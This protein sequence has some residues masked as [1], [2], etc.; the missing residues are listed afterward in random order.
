MA[1]NDQEQQSVEKARE[2]DY[3]ELQLL[4]LQS[5]ESLRQQIDGEIPADLRQLIGVDDVIQEV[6]VEVI[7]NIRS[8]QWRG[9]ESFQS[10]LSEVART[11]LLDMVRTYRR[12]KRGG[13]RARL[14]MS[15]LDVA[16]HI[17]NPAGRSSPVPTPSRIVQSKEVI[18]AVR[19]AVWQLPQN[20]RRVMQLY[21]L[22]Q[23]PTDAIAAV[24][25]VTPGA[26]RALLQRGRQRLRDLLGSSSAWLSHT[27]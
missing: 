12:K 19:A 21:Y 5:C 25:D 18:H 11:C 23:E 14:R 3:T 27:G 15:W 9:P 6:C 24:L 10:W 4:L 16:D 22:D 17:M 20:E 8:F 2:G 7:R 1:M 26:V 13:N